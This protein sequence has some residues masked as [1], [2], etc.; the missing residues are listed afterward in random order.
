MG[1]IIGDGDLFEGMRFAVL[2]V[3]FE[4]DRQALLDEPGPP[5]VE[6]ERRKTLILGAGDLDD[7]R[8]AIIEHMLQGT[9]A[10][11]TTCDDDRREDRDQ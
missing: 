6:G 4:V 1:K 10:V 3:P 9:A 11:P 8:I 2:P 7:S 5:V